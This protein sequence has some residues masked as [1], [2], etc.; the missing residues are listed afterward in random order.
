MYSAFE[1]HLP[2]V[3]EYVLYLTIIISP[4][5]SIVFERWNVG[6]IH[7]PVNGCNHPAKLHWM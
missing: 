2:S 7:G 5:M 6:S 3:E 1:P 4:L